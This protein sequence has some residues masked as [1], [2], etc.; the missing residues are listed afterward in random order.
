MSQSRLGPERSTSVPAAADHAGDLQYE[1]A[2]EALRDLLRQSYTELPLRNAEKLDAV[3]SALLQACGITATLFTA[4]LAPTAIAS[5][6][7]VYK[8][9]YVAGLTL[10]VLALVVL[11]LGLQVR[12]PTSTLRGLDW[13]ALSEWRASLERHV[14]RKKRAQDLGIVFFLLAVFAIFAATAYAVLGAPSGR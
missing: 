12:T 14:A 9:T 8:L 5:N 4:G 7:I 2:Q 3:L 10:F 1:A 11:G 6:N 13:D